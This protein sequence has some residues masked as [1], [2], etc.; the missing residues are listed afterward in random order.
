MRV[1]GITTILIRRAAQE[2]GG[3]LAATVNVSKH[4]E[5]GARRISPLC[6]LSRDRNQE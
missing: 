3:D 4:L 5:F 1:V 2:I 6:D